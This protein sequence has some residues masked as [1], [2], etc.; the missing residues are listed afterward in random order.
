MG[1]QYYFNY[2]LWKAGEVDF[3]FIIIIIN[4]LLIS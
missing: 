2:I 4:S 3:L 1:T